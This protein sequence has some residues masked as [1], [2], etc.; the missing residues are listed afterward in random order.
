[1]FKETKIIKSILWGQRF[2]GLPA[3]QLIPVNLGARI[4]SLRVISRESLIEQA[5][6]IRPDLLIFET[7]TPGEK[8]WSQ[9]INFTKSKLSD[10]GF[11]AILNE[12]SS[13][14][15]IR[16]LAIAQVDSIIKHDRLHLEIPYAIRAFQK[17][18]TFL[19]SQVAKIICSFVQ[20]QL[21]NSLNSINNNVNISSK[22]RG[23]LT[24]LTNRELEVLACLTQGLNYKAI[25]K[26]LFV[27]DSTVKTH[28]NNIFTKLNVNDRTQAVL[29]GLK[30]GIDQIA[31]DIFQRM[32]SAI[33][34]S[35]EIYNAPNTGSHPNNNLFLQ[36]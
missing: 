11:I 26:R 23:L 10:C 21:S 4:H 8:S 19:N 2:S 36:F 17:N 27:S 18:E 16:D 14:D 12:L 6:C 13:Q 29:Y 22:D 5:L 25:A 35:E 20:N 32:E 30:H 33:S 9:L 3:D 24:S 15:L 1:M 7:D 28:V 31:A 34:E